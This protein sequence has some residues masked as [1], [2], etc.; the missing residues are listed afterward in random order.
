MDK[1]SI[2]MQSKCTSLKYA[3]MLQGYCLAVIKLDK[4]G[5][6]LVTRLFQFVGRLIVKT[7]Y[8]QAYNASFFSSCIKS[9]TCR[10]ARS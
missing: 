8:S 6:A 9:E 3:K 1:V 2:M 10:V 7:S 5:T 4:H